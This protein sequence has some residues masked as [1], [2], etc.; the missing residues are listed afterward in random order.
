MKNGVCTPIGVKLCVKNNTN[1]PNDWRTMAVF[2]MEKTDLFAFRGQWKV[3]LG[4]TFGYKLPILMLI[5]N[6]YQVLPNDWRPMEICIFFVCVCVC[7]WGGGGG[8]G[9]SALPRSMKSD[10]WQFLLLDLINFKLCAKKYQSISNGSR[11][12][13]IFLLT[14]HGRMDAGANMRTH[15]PILGD[16]PKVDLTVLR[17]TFLLVSSCK[18]TM[19]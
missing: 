12:M 11:Y 15:K 18:C 17:S 2:A 1:I 13:S 4:N 8:G 14:D 10:I 19:F 9:G 7:V 6:V 3:A 16:T 5:H